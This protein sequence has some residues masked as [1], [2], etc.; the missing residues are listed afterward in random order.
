MVDTEVAAFHIDPALY[1]HVRFASK[2]NT[3]ALSTQRENFASQTP[4]KTYF[5][6]CVF[7]CKSGQRS[8]L[9]FNVSRCIMNIITC[10]N[11]RGFRYVM[12]DGKEVKGTGGNSVFI[13]KT[14]AEGD[15]ISLQVNR[16]FVEITVAP[17]GRTQLS[18]R[19]VR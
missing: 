10:V 3:T 5:V 14:R 4:F 19:C 1:I 16:H 6:A 2:L 15:T 18:Y 17:V 12:V 7:A 11:S 9:A 13:L 8:I